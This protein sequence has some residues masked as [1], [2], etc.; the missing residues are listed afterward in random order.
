[1]I[2]QSLVYPFLDFLLGRGFLGV[3]VVH[4]GEKERKVYALTGVGRVFCE[5][6]FA[7]FRDVYGTV[8]EF[9]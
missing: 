7:R 6:L 1:M 9:C 8:V 3:D 2:S 5:A 4:V